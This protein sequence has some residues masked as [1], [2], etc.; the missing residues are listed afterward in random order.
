MTGLPLLLALALS[1][2]VLLWLSG[3]RGILFVVAGIAL[4]GGV[5]TVTR[6][7]MVEQESASPRK[8]GV[9]SLASTRHAFIGRFTRNENWL[10]MAEAIASRG[11]TADATGILI[12]AVKQHP[13]DY[14][15]WTGLGT[16][17]TEHL[18][19]LNPG[20]ELAFERAIQLAPTYPA[21]RYFYGL[22]KLRSGDRRGALAEWQAVLESA[23]AD[24]SWRGLV[25]DQIRAIDRSPAPDQAAK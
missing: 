8:T 14:A 1:I 18:G 25:E 13:R 15:L 22:A 12:A 9:Q 11:N 21:P 24:A 19:R 4:L 23:P 7:G 20:A 3:T 2:A 5:F 10:A 17:M 6:I 16:M